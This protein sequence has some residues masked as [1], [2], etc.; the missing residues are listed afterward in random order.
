MLTVLT[1]TGKQFCDFG[2]TVEQNLITAEAAN[3]ALG[4]ITWG[5]PVRVPVINSPLIC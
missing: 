2:L 4:L 5:Y 1:S 3:V